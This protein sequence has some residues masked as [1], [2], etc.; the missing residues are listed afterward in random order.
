MGIALTFC[1]TPI[2]LILGIVSIVKAIK[3]GKIPILGVISVMLALAYTFFLW[4]QYY[5]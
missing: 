4:R 2:G 3:A 1:C 5:G